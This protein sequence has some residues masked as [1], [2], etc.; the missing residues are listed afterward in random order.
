MV[1]E[2]C[3]VVPVCGY[4]KEIELVITF[5]CNWEMQTVVRK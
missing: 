5:E 1:G 2:W 3:D 4:G